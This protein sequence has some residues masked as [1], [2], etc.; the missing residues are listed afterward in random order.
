MSV[1]MSNEA[2]DTNDLLR[3]AATGDSAALAELFSGYQQRLRQMVRLRLDRRLQGRVDPSDVLQEAYIDLAQQLPTYLAKPEMPFFLWLRLLTGQRLMRLHRHHLGSAMRDAGREVSLYRGALPQA[4]SASLAA[5]L[6]GR[7]TSASEAAV[8]AE[9]QLLLQ[10]ALNA[11]DPLDR[12]IIAL[13]HF[14]ELTNQETAAVLGLSKSAASNRHVRA[15]TRLQAML[16]GI[17]GF[18]DRHGH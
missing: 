9:Q 5:R 13:R 7:F 14:E 18:L 2:D 4:S 16:E 3:R 11:L 12:E 17:P 10:E 8:R 6:I 1:V 15:L